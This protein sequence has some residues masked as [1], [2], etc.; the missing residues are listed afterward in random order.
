MNNQFNGS[1]LLKV[2]V[3]KPYTITA[4]VETKP[5]PGAKAVAEDYFGKKARQQK[6]T[7]DKKTTVVPAPF[8]DELHFANYE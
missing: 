2:E 1:A 4:G 8:Y 5:V 6:N 7:A 3:Q